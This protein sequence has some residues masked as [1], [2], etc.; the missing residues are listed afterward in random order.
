MYCTGS[1]KELGQVNKLVSL[2]VNKN[3]DNILFISYF[4]LS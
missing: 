2:V 4:H 1:K 3:K